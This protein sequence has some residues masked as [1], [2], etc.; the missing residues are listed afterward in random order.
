MGTAGNTQT[1]V[2]PP[3]CVVETSL[4]RTLCSWD[5]LG[6]TAKSWL[7]PRDQD[8]VM[9]EQSQESLG[10]PGTL[11]DKIYLFLMLVGISTVPRRQVACCN[12]TLIHKNYLTRFW[13]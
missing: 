2:V 7:V 4:R 5:V 10:G 3:E 13:D 1:A 11:R 6:Q 8:R 9:F 12:V